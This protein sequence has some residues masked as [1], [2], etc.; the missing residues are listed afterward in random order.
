MCI[1]HTTDDMGVANPL[2]L[3]NYYYQSPIKFVLVG[4][5]RV[6]DGDIFVS[7]VHHVVKVGIIAPGSKNPVPSDAT[8]PS[9]R[10]V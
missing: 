3:P 6:R 8:L 7:D 2:L 4:Q 9:K 5:V 1:V 10:E